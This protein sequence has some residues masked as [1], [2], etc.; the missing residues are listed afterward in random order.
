LRPP[1]PNAGATLVVLYPVDRWWESAMAAALPVLG[2]ATLAA[3]TAGL[4]LGLGARVVGR[5]RAVEGQTRRIAA[6]NFAAM[7]LPNADDE[8]RD[9]AQSVN[10]MADRL[11]KLQAGLRDAERWQLLGQVSSGLAHQLRNGVA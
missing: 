11:V 7:P 1:H 8:L 10:A 9:L 4:T 2:F 3:L 6:G 5:V